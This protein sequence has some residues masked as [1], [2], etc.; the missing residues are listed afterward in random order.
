M[1]GYFLLQG[2]FPTQGL[3]PGLLYWQVDS[4]AS[5]PPRKPWLLGLNVNFHEIHGYYFLAV[6]PRSAQIRWKDDG[7]GVRRPAPAVLGLALIV[8]EMRLRSP[9]LSLPPFF[10]WKVKY[11]LAGPESLSF[12][13][14]NVGHRLYL[15]LKMFFNTFQNSIF[16]HVN[17]QE[18]VKFPLAWQMN[19]SW[20]RAV[21]SPSWVLCTVLQGLNNILWCLAKGK[22]PTCCKT[23]ERS[24]SCVCGF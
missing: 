4:L 1:C 11:M 14:P 17:A 9:D 24:S 13:K 6:A 15:F 19:G 22:T 5:E 21:L 16:C 18:Q 10:I 8:Q 3:N 20:T 7:L 12:L 2:I 23:K